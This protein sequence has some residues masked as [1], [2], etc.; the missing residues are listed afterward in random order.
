MPYAPRFRLIFI[1]AILMLAS[2]A[3][4]NGGDA[5]PPGGTTVI[6]TISAAASLKDALNEIKQLYESTHDDVLLSFNYGASGALQQ[7]IEQGAPVD[8]FLAAASKNMDALVGQGL[9]ME[10]KHTSLLSNALVVVTPTD[11]VVLSSI[12][13]LTREDVT[14]IA[15]GIPASV[16]AGNYAQQ[17]LWKVGIWEELRTKTVQAKDVRQVLQYVETGN[18]DAGFVYE[19]DARTSDNVRVAFKVDPDAHERIDYPI[20]VVKATK[21]REQAVS[22]YD[23]LSSQASLDIFRK[24]GFTVS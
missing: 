13:D 10:D 20:G 23:F 8:L 4:S 1:L 9:I 18:V 2:I 14:Q 12:T 21:H 11:G 6:M 5:D 16:P 24:Y 17:A 3:C 22:V 7:Q 15:I 19:T